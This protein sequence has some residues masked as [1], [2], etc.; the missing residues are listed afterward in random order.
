MPAGFVAPLSFY[1]HPSPLQSRVGL[2]DLP[3]NPSET[4]KTTP[5]SL[6]NNEVHPG[7]KDREVRSLLP[8]GHGAAP[9]AP[10][11]AN[12]LVRRPLRR[13]EPSPTEAT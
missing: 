5:L 6:A 3:A 4:F 10:P 11:R 8:M 12:A 1:A 7:T 13:Q 9:R 2:K